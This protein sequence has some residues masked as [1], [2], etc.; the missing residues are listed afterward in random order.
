MRFPTIFIALAAVVLT[1]PLFAANPRAEAA[2]LAAL[3]K[4]ET[5]YLSMNYASGAARLDKALRGCAP[6]NC[7]AGT[8]AALLR[9]IGTMEFRAGDRGFA[10]KA[11]GEAL[12]LQ[13]TIDLNPSYDSPDLRAAWNEVKSPGA[14]APAAGTT[15]P[16]AGEPAPP[17][18]PKA[19]VVPPP[20]TYPQPTKGDFVHT[21]IPEQKIDVPLPVYIEGGPSGVY[22]VILRYKHSEEN[23][24]A[25][26]NHMDL[27]HVGK[28]WGGLIPCN[29]VV[30]GI[31]RYYIQAYNKDMDPVGA[32]GDAKN[33]YQVPIREELAGPAP[34]LP[35]KNPPK[36]C[37]E[38]PKPEPPEKEGATA[39]GDKAD[40]GGEAD[41]EGKEEEKAERPRTSGGLRRYW[42]GGGLSLDF[43]QMPSG[44]DLCRLNPNTALPA[45]DKHIYCTDSS[46]TDFP[47][48]SATGRQINTAET[49]GNAGQSNGGFVPGD[50]RLFVS[51]DYAINAN[52]LVGARVGYVL[53]RYPGQNAVTDNYA[54]GTGFWGEL[55]LTAVLGRDALKREGI[56]PLFFAGGGVSAFDAHTSGTVILTNPTTMKQ[57]SVPVDMWWTNGPGF[58]DLGGGVRY[59]PTS[60]IGIVGALRVNLSFGNNGLIS[61]L[62]PEISA[63]YGF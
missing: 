22:H 54:F 42:V 43:V 23:D 14:P 34:H 20:P 25:E 29:A 33:P 17:P 10:N 52:F 62:G 47:P 53:L 49:M 59:A 63:Q 8:Q 4:A 5:D 35:N 32:N 57:Q 15:P 7:S 50:L 51:F 3:T 19:P 11:F 39:K 21:P 61:A 60:Q 56:A 30:G 31:M 40:T 24:D 2:A 26:W 58:I 36:I 55:R 41:K 9:D 38:K 37:H 28:G 45:N 16:P 27:G 13:P 6:A 48:R 18:E 44:T 1:R 12:K 46:G